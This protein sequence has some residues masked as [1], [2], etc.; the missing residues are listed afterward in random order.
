MRLS[1][2]AIKDK[3]TR[4][5]STCIADYC[6]TGASAAACE[7]WVWYQKRTLQ[8]NGKYKL[9]SQWVRALKCARDRPS[10]LACLCPQSAGSWASP[11]QQ[12]MACWMCSVRLARTLIES[13]KRLVMASNKLHRIQIH[14]TPWQVSCDAKLMWMCTRYLYRSVCMLVLWQRLR[15]AFDALS[16]T[17]QS[18]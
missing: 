17:I 2:E 18:S 3:C 16:R 11:T 14:Y 4:S 12:C 6:G 8:C 10:A 5:C 15:N 9:K 1:S 7:H 13:E